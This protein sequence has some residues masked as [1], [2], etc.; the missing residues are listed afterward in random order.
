MDAVLVIL[1][2]T[3][4]KHEGSDILTDVPQS[5]ADSSAQWLNMDYAKEKITLP[6]TWANGTLSQIQPY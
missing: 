5:S 4:G 2:W 6:R 1:W 3:L